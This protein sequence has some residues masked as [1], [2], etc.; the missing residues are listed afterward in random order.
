MPVSHTGWPFGPL[1]LCSGALHFR[2]A[3]ACSLDPPHSLTAAADCPDSPRPP[4][5]RPQSP[6]TPHD[7]VYVLPLLTIL[8]SK[9]CRVPVSPSCTMQPVFPRTLPSLTLL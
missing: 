8:T 6:R 1:L 5:L 7:R 2:P 3:V 9:V 4:S